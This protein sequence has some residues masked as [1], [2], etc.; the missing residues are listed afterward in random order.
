MNAYS[1]PVDRLLT[2]GRPDL[3]A[4]TLDYTIFGIGP[5]HVPE[6]IRLIQDDELNNSDEP[7]CYAMIHAWRALGQFQA[8]EAVEPLLDLLARQEGDDWCDWVTEEVP[9][10]LSK[11]GPE[12]IPA[13]VVRFRDQRKK[14]FVPGYFA[15]TLKEIAIRHPD[16][17]TEV[18]HHLSQF[19]ESATENNSSINGWVIGDLI[20]LKAVEAWP[21]IEQA[22]A[23]NSVDEGILGDA[24]KVKFELGLGPKPPEKPRWQKRERLGLA[25]TPK[26]RAEKRKHLKK[27]Q[28][29]QSKRKK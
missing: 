5:E 19:L 22:F 17:R 11:F 15:R 20:D 21:V 9:V 16:V 18:I 7:Q 3:D 1:P 24:A 29:K 6:L 13:V 14:K 2:L 4:P 27:S 28:K 25:L 10:V 8:P 26:E 23:S 12:I